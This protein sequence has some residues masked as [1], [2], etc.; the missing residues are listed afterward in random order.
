[1]L[2]FDLIRKALFVNWDYHKV[3]SHMVTPFIYSPMAVF[4]CIQHSCCGKFGLKHWS[5]VFLCRWWTLWTPPSIPPP[6]L[7]FSWLEVHC[8]IQW[9][10]GSSNPPHALTSG[11]HRTWVERWSQG[12]PVSREPSKWMKRDRSFDFGFAGW[13]PLSLW[14]DHNWIECAGI[15]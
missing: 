15:S 6:L 5:L 9:V 13:L 14:Q 11:V 7:C 2:V 8:S 10:R 12:R 3:T 4:I 1:M